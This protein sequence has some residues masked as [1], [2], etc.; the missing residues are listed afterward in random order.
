MITFYVKAEP[1]LSKKEAGLIIRE[2]FVYATALEKLDGHVD[3]DIIK[4]HPKEY[5][6]FKAALDA[7]QEAVYA[8]VKSAPGKLINPLDF[9][10]AEA[11]EAKPIKKK[12]GK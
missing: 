1:K 6:V 9:V 3:E 5:P 4:S 8:A 2:H 7:N 10:T 12:S 11:P